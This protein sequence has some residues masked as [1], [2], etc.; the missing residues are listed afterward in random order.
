M[1][2]SRQ[3]YWN[4]LPCPPPEDLPSPEMEPKSLMSPAL[5]GRF[6]TTSATREASPIIH[7]SLNI[8]HSQGHSTTF[9][10][11][12]FRKHKSQRGKTEISHQG[13]M[14]IVQKKMIKLTIPYS[15]WLRKS[16]GISSP[17]LYFKVGLEPGSVSCP[18]T[19]TM[20]VKL[21]G[22]FW[23]LWSGLTGTAINQEQWEHTGPCWSWLSSGSTG[24]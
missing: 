13:L 1:G 16:P 4:G 23:G 20:T 17:S 9:S 21:Q 14:K 18:V 15:G 24:V 8:L 19:L 11:T 12:Q 6:F 5:V 2:F 3:D 7:Q 10:T 22:S